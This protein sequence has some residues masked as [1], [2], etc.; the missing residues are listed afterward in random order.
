M[1]AEARVDGH[2]QYQ[3]HQLQRFFQR[4][5]R[6]CRIQHQTGLGAAIADAAERPVQ[7]LGALRMYGD[8]IGAGLE[9]VTNQAVHGFHHQVDVHEC[10]DAGFAQ[11]CQHQRAHAQIRHVVVVHDIEV[12]RVGTR[13]EDSLALGTQAGEVCGQDRG[14]DPMRQFAAGR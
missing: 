10:P 14:C 11:R 13:F 12:N 2:H 7:V 3:I 5:E 8:Q 9:K 6:C 1:A 4:T